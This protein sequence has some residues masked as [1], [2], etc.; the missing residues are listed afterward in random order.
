MKPSIRFFAV[1][2]LA[3]AVSAFGGFVLHKAF[4]V[5]SCNQ[6]GYTP[7][8]FMGFCGSDKI[9]DYEHAVFVHDLEPEMTRHLQ[10]AEVLFLGNSRALYA[11]SAQSIYDSFAARGA[12][13][14]ILAFGYGEMSDF[15]LTMMRR[16]NLRPKVLIINADPF[17]FH[18]QSDQAVAAQR[19]D[20]LSILHVY[21]KKLGQDISRVT[22]PI[23]GCIQRSG[24]VYR[25]KVNGRWFWRDYIMPDKTIPFDPAT[26]A[27]VDEY[28][29]HNLSVAA[30]RAFLDAVPVPSHCVVLTGVPTPRG[31]FEHV[32]ELLGSKLG[33]PVINVK[34][35]D[36]ASL[37]NEHLNT[38]SS[39]R[40]SAALSQ[41]LTPV[42]DR[43]LE[44]K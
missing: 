44:K 42:L 38:D 20:I 26:T 23:F 17:F 1:F 19:T 25:D 29:P 41:A 9:G 43:C 13:Y 40:W 16:Y 3:A 6:H 31:N 33:L 28:F 10:S 18:W 35:P 22:C 36:L 24:A 37:D 5:G 15:A 34:I 7:D 27:N 11:F 21:A 12:K 32:A 2:F 4:A 39:E 30:G 8:T 14:F